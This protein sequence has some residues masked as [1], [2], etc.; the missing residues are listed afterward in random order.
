[1]EKRLSKSKMRQKKFLFFFWLLV[2]T[3]GVVTYLLFPDRINLLFLKELAEEHHTTALGIYLLLLSA[4]GL[5][6]IPS[7]PLLLAGIL[8]FDPVELFIV[9]MVGILTSSTIVYYFSKYLGF[10]EYFETRYG[11]EVKKIRYWLKDKELPI[12]VGWSF[13]PFAPT[14]LIVYVGSTLGIHIFKCLLGV[15]VGE[16]VLNAFYILSAKMILHP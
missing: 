12:I 8:L 7:T 14:D 1:M 10:A 9:N 4:R 16:S 3:G 11:K 13:F 5:T 6:M 15:L 2:V